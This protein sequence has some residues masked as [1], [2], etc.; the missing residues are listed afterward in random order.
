[1][2]A[3]PLD[4]MPS[5]RLR[6]NDSGGRNGAGQRGGRQELNRLRQGTQSSY[7]ANLATTM[8]RESGELFA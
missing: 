1:M 2:H 7:A 8:K 4:R 6:Y 3:A 5:V